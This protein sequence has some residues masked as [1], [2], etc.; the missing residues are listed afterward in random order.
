MEATVC[1]VCRKIL[2]LCAQEIENFE[3][4]LVGVF[5]SS[6]LSVHNLSFSLSIY[7]FILSTPLVWH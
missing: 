1:G 3:K 7:L 4:E 6:S 5:F 2:S